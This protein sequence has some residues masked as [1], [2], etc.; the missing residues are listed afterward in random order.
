MAVQQ[1]TDIPR[2]WAS[3]GGQYTQVPDTTSDAGRASW[4]V[5]FPP[6][7]SL[8]V[9]QGGIP[10]NRLDFQGVLNA[11]SAHAVFKQAG[12]TYAWNSGTAYPKGAVVLYTDGKLY[13]ATQNTNAGDSPT[14]SKWTAV[15]LGNATGDF[16]TQAALT[17][18][19]SAYLLKSG[20]TMTGPIKTADGVLA[21]ADDVNTLLILNG[22]D[23][24]DS[25]HLALRG[26]N[27]T[28]PAS[29]PQSVAGSAEL[30]AGTTQ[31]N[32]A[33]FTVQ[34][35]TAEHPNG[36]ALLDG[37]ALLFA[38]VISSNAN[39]SW[40][41]LGQLQLCWGE[42]TTGTSHN[43]PQAFSAKPAMVASM[44]NGAGDP[45]STSSLTA[46]AFTIVNKNRNDYDGDSTSSACWIA[47][48]PWS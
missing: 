45:A 8:P 5:G 28:P 23:W 42:S 41:R 10:P 48:G 32:L 21:T 38:P 30:I 11:L 35:K 17:Q 25:A 13:C 37:L 33:R 9:A 44:D 14:G 43:F 46:T 20:G 6:E 27:W 29:A 31:A 47:I 40:V 3:N 22:Q 26:S 19:L 39:G 2:P 18:A 36:Q 15:V 24:Q 16:V 1:P 4:S 34:P 12:G 7:T